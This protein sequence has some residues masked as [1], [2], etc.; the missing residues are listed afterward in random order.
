LIETDT[1]TVIDAEN[2]TT[3]KCGPSFLDPKAIRQE[4]QQEDMWC[5]LQFFFELMCLFIVKNVPFIG[6]DVA[7]G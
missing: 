2:L 5:S 1:D 3:R 6:V 7:Q 4:L